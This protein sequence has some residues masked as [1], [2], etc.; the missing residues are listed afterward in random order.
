MKLFIAICFF[1]LFVSLSHSC[2]SQKEVE[3]SGVKYVLHTVKKSETVFSLCQKYKVTQK[4]LLQANPGITAI[5]KAGSTVKIPVGKVEVAVPQKPEVPKPVQV[6]P[7]YYYHKVARKQTIFSIAK[8]FGISAN[9]LIRFNPELSNGLMVGQVLK[10]PVKTLP[11]STEPMSV[12]QSATK[13]KVEKGETLFSLAARFGVEVSE[14]KNANPSLFSRSLEAGETIVIPVKSSTKNQDVGKMEVPRT[15]SIVEI[16]SEPPSDCDPINAK[17]QKYKAALILPFNLPGNDHIIPSNID[18]TTLLSRIK[19]NSQPIPASGDTTTIVGLT[20]IDPKL[21]GF[22]EFY[23]GVLLAIDSLQSKGMNIELYVFDASNQQMINALLQ[24]DEF[25]DLNLII[26][27]VYPELQENM[28]AFA[29]KNRIPMISPL[30]P[31]GNFEQNNSWYFKVNP[32]KEFQI[33]QTASYIGT[34]FSDKNFILLQVSGNSTSTEAKLAQMSIEKLA[35]QAGKNMFHEYNFQKLGVNSIKPILDETGENI[36]FIPTDNEAQVSVAVTNLNALA[37]NYN[38]VLMGTPTLTKL[39]SIQTENF[40]RV[41]L[42]Y[43]SHYFIDYNKPLVRRFVSQYRETFSA[44]PTQF[45]HQGFDVAYYFLSALYR[46]GKDFRNCLPD[47]PMELTQMF[48]DFRK[49]TPMGGYMNTGLFVTAYERNF[50]ILN[51]G[52]IGVK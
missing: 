35:G 49:V 40:H 2:F 50:D 1:T 4:E 6:E 25:R 23:E 18:R 15:V 30:S 27:P 8:Q 13:Y 22:L 29:A 11:Q 51:Y 44:E 37:E 7:E 26:G 10:I 52:A 5:L 41:R 31:V 16:N 36:F 28:A 45:S 9:D 32:T 14:L 17:N 12:Q 39:K 24:L 3:I 47:Y 33:E 21:E 20:N 34:E 43:L 48:F 38:I 46:Y 42:R 19:L